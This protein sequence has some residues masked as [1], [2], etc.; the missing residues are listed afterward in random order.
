MYFEYLGWENSLYIAKNLGKWGTKISK[1]QPAYKQFCL[2]SKLY[3]F[4]KK[5]AST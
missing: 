1:S 4:L 2:I 3:N 5:E